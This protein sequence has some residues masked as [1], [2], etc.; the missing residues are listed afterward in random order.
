M[1]IIIILGS[2][3]NVM[4]SE[5]D[6]TMNSFDDS[7][8]ECTPRKFFASKPKPTPLK[9]KKRLLIDSEDSLGKKYKVPL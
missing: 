2:P 4:N 3:N 8:I 5:E 7:E 6:C 9:A 1:C